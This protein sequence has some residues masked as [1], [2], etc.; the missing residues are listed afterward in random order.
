LGSTNKQN[1]KQN[2]KDIFG[3]S[4]FE[5]CQLMLFCLLTIVKVE[6]VLVNVNGLQ[7]QL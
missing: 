5:G 6:R 3:F 4:V 2:R 7:E 1:R